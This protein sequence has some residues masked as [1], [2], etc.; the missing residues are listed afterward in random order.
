MKPI[1]LK[2]MRRTNC[3]QPKGKVWFQ[4]ND[5]YADKDKDSSDVLPSNQE[6][7]SF[8]KKHHP[9]VYKEVTNDK[10]K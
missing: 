1:Q 6:I 4:K 3:W 8:M 2:H 9:K 7:E 10:S 5:D